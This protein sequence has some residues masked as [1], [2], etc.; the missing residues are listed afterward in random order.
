[1]LSILQLITLAV[2]QGITEFLPISSSGHLLLTRQVLDWHDPGP[3]FD[4]AVHVGTLGAVL[5][6]FRGEAATLCRGLVDACR[7]RRSD[8]ATL[9][10][11]L[12]LATVP[13][14]IAAAILLLTGW[15]DLLRQPLVIAL[16]T[17]GF[18]LPL[19]WA[20][21][22]RDTSRSLADC[23]WRD[24]LWVGLAQALAVVPGA[25]RAGVC[26]TAARF[27]DLSRRDA[28]RLAMLMS[29]PTILIFGG[30]SALDLIR[31]GD[32]DFGLDV[33]FATALSFATALIAIWALMAWL[34]RSSFTPFVIYR[35][36][37]GGALLVWLG[38]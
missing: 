20:D 34:Q 25:S 5:L 36:L 32:F 29:I 3:N 18:A 21:K 35:L 17:I 7:G 13:V 9:F 22:R 33:L 10:G 24:F 14:V 26:V 2:V 31:S 19:W 28:A 6:Y 38:L 11:Y 15:L 30:Y 1:M 23:G 16:A 12:A 4:V 8:A 27:L 37:L